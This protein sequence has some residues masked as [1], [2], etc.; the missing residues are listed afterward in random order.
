MAANADSVPVSYRATTVFGWFVMACAAYL[1]ITGLLSAFSPNDITPPP[2]WGARQMGAAGALFQGLLWAATGLAILQRR[3][4]AIKL[5]WVITILYGF[6]IL[7]RGLIPLEI[8]LWIIWLLI[9]I[10]FSK[11]K[12]LVKE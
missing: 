7:F 6:G 5:L 4:I 1:L 8:L 9:T 11:K 12:I 3:K 2:Y 10:W